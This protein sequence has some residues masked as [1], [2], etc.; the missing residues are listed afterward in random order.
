[1]DKVAT[2]KIALS[3]RIFRERATQGKFGTMGQSRVGLVCVKVGARDYQ[4]KA[5]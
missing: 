5:L 4:N 3:L 1:M 2:S